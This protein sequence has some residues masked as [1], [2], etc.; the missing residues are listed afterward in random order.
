MKVIRRLELL[1]SKIEAFLDDLDKEYLEIERLIDVQ[2]KKRKKDRLLS[3]AFHRRQ[4]P[5]RPPK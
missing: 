1:R 4:Q 3:Q 2:K 5:I